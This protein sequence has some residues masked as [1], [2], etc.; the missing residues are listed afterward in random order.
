MEASRVT[1][2]KKSKAI[3]TSAGKVKLTFFFDQ[4]GPLLKNFLQRGI[5]VNAHRYS[6]TL[7]TLR[8]AIKSKR[9]GKLTCGTILFHDNASPHTAHTIM[10]LLQEFKWTVPGH[11]TY[12]PDLS[13][14][15]YAIF[16]PLKKALSWQSIHLLRRHQAVRA[17]LVHNAGPGILRD[18]HSPPCVAVGQVP[19]QPG[20]ILLICRCW[21]LFLGLRLVS[22]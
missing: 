1:T 17:E 21:F 16:G 5:T 7:T 11:P 15:D 22:F 9:P 18:S 12:S 19:Q 2:T 10:A 14:C 8:Q 4:D 13:P 3:H 20:P 6:Q